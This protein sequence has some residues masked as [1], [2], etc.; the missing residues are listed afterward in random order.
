MGTQQILLIVLS[1]IIV[2]VAIAVGITMFR[3]Q[4][5]NSNV[6]AVSSELNNY[7]A[8]ALQWWKTPLS[9]GGAGQTFDA[10]TIVANLQAYLG[11]PA[12][13]VMGETGVFQVT[14]AAAAD[15]SIVL[16]G[17]GKEIK[18]GKHPKVVTTVRLNTGVIT[19]NAAGTD[20]DG[21]F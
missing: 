2:G 11:L 5:Y 6:Q 15:T 21:G 13:P 14:S 20:A 16:S 17:I 3:N 1:V 18:G 12:T 7:G 10:S 9:Q 19:A 8:Q 4:A